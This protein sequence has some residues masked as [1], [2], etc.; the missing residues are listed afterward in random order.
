MHLKKYYLFSHQVHC[1]ICY[2]GQSNCHHFLHTRN[3]AICYTNHVSTYYTDQV[4]PFY[5]GNEL[6][7]PQNLD[8]KDK[9]KVTH[10]HLSLPFLHHSHVPS[11][12]PTEVKITL[13][14]DKMKKKNSKLSLRESKAR[15]EKR[16]KRLRI[17]IQ[18]LTTETPRLNIT[19]MS[20]VNKKQKL[21]IITQG[22]M[23]ETPRLNSITVSLHDQ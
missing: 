17:I 18:G 20:L 23:T 10:S 22:L 21:K 9:K 16:K 11:L 7:S 4:L 13:G 3:I 12:I 1:T 2:T 14:F 8:S 6:L 19:I 5:K 15:K